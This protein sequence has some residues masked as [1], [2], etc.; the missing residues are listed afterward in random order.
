MPNDMSEMT[1]NCVMQILK[2]RG[3]LRNCVVFPGDKM[4]TDF[5]RIDR[6]GNK[7]VFH[8][9][10]CELKKECVQNTSFTSVCSMVQMH[11]L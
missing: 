4:K 6:S 7:N 9:F 1:V 5:G 3:L 8:G 2:D 11:C 10:K